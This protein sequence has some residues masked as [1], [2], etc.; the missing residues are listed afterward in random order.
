MVNQFK[1]YLGVRGNKEAMKQFRNTYWYYF[2]SKPT[3]EKQE[4]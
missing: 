1:Q 3:E 2:D 4:K